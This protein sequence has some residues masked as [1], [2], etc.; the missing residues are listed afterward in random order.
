MF[1]K[2]NKGKRKELNGEL[3]WG[4][5]FLFFFLLSLPF[6]YFSP[7]S[8]TSLLLI[9]LSSSSSV[10]GRFGCFPCGVYT[11]DTANSI[12][13]LYF[14]LTLKFADRVIQHTYVVKGSPFKSRPHYRTY[15]LLSLWDTLL[16]SIQSNDETILFLS[17]GFLLFF[18][19][20]FLT[21]IIIFPI[22][23][24]PII[25]FGSSY[26][27]VHNICALSKDSK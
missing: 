9:L 17:V 4:F 7:L 14:I 19:L 11:A 20:Y 24:F 6:P 18:L 1:S 10:S 26:F 2:W 22:L 5:R 25:I 8:L 3:Q 15:C 13:Y 23:P 27:T 16:V 21:F 12:I